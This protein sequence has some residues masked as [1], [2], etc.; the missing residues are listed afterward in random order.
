[1]EPG[2]REQIRLADPHDAARWLEFELEKRAAERSLLEFTKQSWDAV[3]PEPFQSNWHVE[4]TCD[5]LEAVANQQILRL[6]I[7]IPPRH[8]KSLGVNVMLPCWTWAQNPNPD[9]DPDFTGMIMPETWRGPG[10]RFA[11][12]SHAQELSTEHSMLCRRVLESDYYRERWG[13]RVQFTKDENLKTV[14]SN[15]AGGRRISGVISSMTGKGGDII[16]FDD[17]HD[18]MTVDSDVQRNEVIRFW[19]EQLQNRHNSAAGVFIIVMQRTHSRDLSGYILAKEMKAQYLDLTNFDRKSFVHLCFPAR[20]EKKHPHPTRTPVLRQ[21]PDGTYETWKDPRTV[22][23]QALWEER[24]PVK[25]LDEREKNMTPHSIAGQMQ[26]RPVGRE[27]GKFKRAWF[28]EDKF[29]ELHEVPLETRWVRHWDLAGTAKNGADYTVGLKLGL[30]PNGSYVVAS[31]IR[32]QFEGH[33]VRDLIKATAGMD[34]Y[35]CDISLPQDPG[36][37]GKIQASDFVRDLAG[38]VVSTERESGNKAHRANPVAAQAS[39]GHLYI[40]RAIWNDA[41]LDELCLFPSAPNDDQV[42]ALSGAFARF[43]MQQGEFSAGGVGGLT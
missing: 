8:M 15:T 39:H 5:H 11:Y 22:E 13:D 37:A 34:G 24:F 29:M 16:V 10:V 26:Q 12:I 7:N 27:G 18:V 17:P 25:E 43:I 2:L 40:V 6:L 41:F 42:D 20:F 23:G 14:Y 35:S 33:D 19:T 36:Q 4:A 1:M 9:N 30:M 3:I 31:V 32:N 38:Y 21:L 28:T